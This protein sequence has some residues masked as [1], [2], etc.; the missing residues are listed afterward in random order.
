MKVAFVDETY[1][2]AQSIMTVVKNDR[3][4]STIV[5]LILMTQFIVLIWKCKSKLWTFHASRLNS[6]NFVSGLKQT[7]I[8]LMI[9]VFSSWKWINQEWFDFI[10]LPHL[11]LVKFDVCCLLFNF[12]MFFFHCLN[13]SKWI[14]LK[15]RSFQWVQSFQES[16][17][18][19]LNAVS[20]SGLSSSKKETFFPFLVCIASNIVGLIH[21]KV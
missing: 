7:Y 10:Y 2:Y 5:F 12:K 18:F 21:L 16:Y 14:I 20:V 3:Y 6:F 13:H 19:P 11:P 1:V 4:K 9:W 17:F 15:R 8:L